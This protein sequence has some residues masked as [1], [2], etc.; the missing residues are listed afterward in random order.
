MPLGSG[1]AV[2]GGFWIGKWIIDLGA[3]PAPQGS[4]AVNAGRLD[5]VLRAQG[6][7]WSACGAWWGLMGGYR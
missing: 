3:L 6:G 5:L 4:G 1:G 2:K 7:V